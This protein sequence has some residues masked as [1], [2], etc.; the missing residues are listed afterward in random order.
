MMRKQNRYWI[1]VLSAG[2]LLTTAACISGN[3]DD[4]DSADVMLAVSQVTIPAITG[5]QDSLTGTCTFTLTE[6]SATLQNLPKSDVVG[7]SAMQTI[8]MDSLTLTYAWD[9]GVVFP[10]RT[11]AVGATIAPGATGSV[12]F[13]IFAGDDLNNAPNPRDGHSCSVTMV[14]TGHT[15]A[16]DV[17]T[18]RSGGVA[19]V[20]PCAPDTDGDGIPN[21]VDN[22]PSVSNA[23]QQ[24]SDGD[25]VGDACDPN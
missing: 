22:C 7:D 18:A 20:N 13:P 19:T 2:L 15:L 1:G 5:A 9:D 16:G 4:G 25:G 6:S 8:A 10:V 24:D 17:V 3:V 23:N 21:I 11:V 12:R 14:F